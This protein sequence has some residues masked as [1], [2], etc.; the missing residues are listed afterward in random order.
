MTSPECLLKATFPAQAPQ[1]Q[2]IRQR[3]REIFAAENCPGALADQWVLAINEACMNIIQHAYG[4]NKGLAAEGDIIVEVL[5]SGDEWTFRLTDFAQPVDKTKVC[6]RD[7]DDIRPGG[8]GV[9]F[10]HE[11]MDEV[12]F[13]DSTEAAN[14][15]T[16]DCKTVDCKTRGNILQM[17]SHVPHKGES[18]I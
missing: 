1:L 15:G 13:L 7:L 8:L 2:T 16:V 14:I 17:K 5:R 10:I 4:C 6:S 12:K 11:I 18:D 9:H 3:L